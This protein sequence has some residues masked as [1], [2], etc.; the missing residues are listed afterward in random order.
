MTL[1]FVFLPKAHT[2]VLD[3]VELMDGVG[4]SVLRT[5]SPGYPVAR[6]G[7]AGHCP[8]PWLG[9]APLLALL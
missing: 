4:G 2:G 5:K 1:Q 7:G 8:R 3:P 9:A 6:V